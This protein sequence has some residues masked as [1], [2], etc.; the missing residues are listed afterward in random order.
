MNV[1]VTNFESHNVALAYGYASCVDNRC[2]HQISNITKLKAM[3]ANNAYGNETVLFQDNYVNTKAIDDISKHGIEYD[4]L[5]HWG[6]C[7]VVAIS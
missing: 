4:R 2:G 5:T 7:N 6:R 1:R 3:W